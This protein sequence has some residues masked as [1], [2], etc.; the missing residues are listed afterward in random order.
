MRCSRIVPVGLLGLVIASTAPRAEHARLETRN[1]ILVVTDGLRWQEVFAGADSLLLFGDPQRVGGDTAALRREFWRATAAERREALLPFVWTTI[2][3]R[4]QLYG[5]VAAGS[6]VLVTNRLNFSYPGYHE[7][8]A[9]FVDTLIDSNEHGPNPNVTVFEWLNRN[10]DYRGKVAAFATWG[11]FDEIFAKQRS[12][13]VMHTGW[14]QPYEN[15]RDAAD[16]LLNRLYATTHREWPNNA[17]DAFMHAVMLR[18]ARE[19]RPRVLFVGY[20]ETDEWAHLGRYDRYLRAARRVDS[21]VAQLWST[22]QSH[23]DTRGRTTLIV[24]TDH[25]RGRTAGDWDEHG[26]AIAGAEEM[27]L[28]VVGPDTPPRGERQNAAPVIQSQ[29]ASTLAGFLGF[30]YRGE[31]RRAAP[32]IADAFR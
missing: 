22:Y 17:W 28:A 32:A 7:M 31:T 23:P 29:I 9:G 5:N 25:G 19:S 6:R 13:I 26:A 15:P 27:W 2:G 30:D 1:V 4:G 18:Y 3:R 14:A 12:G 11:V 20:G 21:L 24:T 16:S 10:E 8:L